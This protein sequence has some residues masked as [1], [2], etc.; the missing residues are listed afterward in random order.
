METNDSK[1]DFPLVMITSD[2][3]QPSHDRDGFDEDP[4]TLQSY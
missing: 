3:S 4:R 2:E 1:S